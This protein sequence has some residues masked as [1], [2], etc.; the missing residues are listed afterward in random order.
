[1]PSTG[2][3]DIGSDINIAIGDWY[4]TIINIV[5]LKYK[6]FKQAFNNDKHP[7]NCPRR[8]DGSDHQL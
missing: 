1:M 7:V 3:I 5:G 8:S 4:K 6:N 2:I